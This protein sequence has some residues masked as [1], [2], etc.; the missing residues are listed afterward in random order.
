MGTDRSLWNQS[1]AYPYPHGWVTEAYQ[2]PDWCRGGHAAGSNG[3]G[4]A[5]AVSDEIPSLLTSFDNT[6]RREL[7]E[8]TF[9]NVGEP[10]K[11]VKR[12][13]DSLYAAVYLKTCC[14][15][16]AAAGS[17]AADPERRF[18]FINAWNEWA[19]GMALEPSDVYERS[20]LEAIRDVKAQ[21]QTEGCVL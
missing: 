3:R 21:I 6:P 13:R 15:N 1:V 7:Y 8:A 10:D 4:H 5:A 2:V 20:F 12:F 14:V 18:V 17:H 16:G 9:Y 19:E 11:V